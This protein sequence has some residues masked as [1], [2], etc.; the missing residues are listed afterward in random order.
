MAELERENEI[1]VRLVEELE[2]AAFAL[3][4]GQLM[5]PGEVAEGLRL[6]E[7]YRRRHSQRIAEDLLL[8]ETGPG[9]TGV[10]FH[11]LAAIA[12]GAQA[13]GELV[14][15]ARTC[16]NEFASGSVGA[17]SRLVEAL[18]DLSELER[19][20][21]NHETD[22][23]LPCLRAE[24]PGAVV[25]SGSTGFLH[26]DTVMED[27]EGHIRRYLKPHLGSETRDLAVHCVHPGCLAVAHTRPI[28]SIDGRF[29]LEVPRGWQAIS[30]LTNTRKGGIIPVNVRFTCP[31]HPEEIRE[32]GAPGP[33][34]CGCCDPLP[35]DS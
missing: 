23:L 18:L 9:A 4:A 33:S 35:V 34:P 2:E 22:Y 1:T 10:C 25:Q 29:G 17:R 21:L 24:I 8:P 26:P 7:Q 6:L 16:L 11:E 13:E 5:L 32:S 12:S 19:Q 28:P 14:G 20:A 3:K 30:T 31:E 15:R 27:L